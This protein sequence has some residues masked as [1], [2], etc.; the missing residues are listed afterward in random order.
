MNM[1][2]LP[3]TCLVS[4]SVLLDVTCLYTCNYV[5]FLVHVL[6]HEERLGNIFRE[7]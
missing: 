6:V 1:Y 2:G 4:I 3:K 5:S 7:L